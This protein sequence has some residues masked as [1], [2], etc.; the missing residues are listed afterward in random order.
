MVIV[1]GP[2]LCLALLLSGLLGDNGLN[3]AP[4]R[5]GRAIPSSYFGLTINY[6]GQPTSPWPEVP[7]SGIRLWGAIY[8]AE[9]NPAPGVFD[10]KRFDAIL[11]A[12]QRH[13]VDVTFNLAYTPKWASSVS[14]AKPAFSPGAS[15]P[16]ADIGHW[17]SF[18]EAAVKRAAGRIR[19]WEVWN[20]PEDPTYYSGDVA[21][22]VLLQRTAYETIKR[23][24]PTLL[25]I[26]PSSI[27]TAE[28]LRWQSA[29]LA[30]GGGKYAD[31]LG[32]HGYWNDPKPEAIVGI[33]KRFRDLFA[34]HGL[35][36]KPV[37]D[38][39]GGWPATMEDPDAQ[40]AF[41]ARS[42]LIKWA[43]GVDRFHWYAYE[44]GGANYGKL[45]DKSR[46]LLM[47]GRAYR[48]VN[49][50]LVG[51]TMLAIE[52]RGRVWKLDLQLADGRKAL[53]IWTTEGTSTYV[54]SPD[55]VACEDLEGAQMPLRGGKMTIGPKPILFTS[56][57]QKNP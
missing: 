53:A 55:Y 32:F 21:T 22:M 12:S 15:A 49:R 4:D 20:E 29:F 1:V 23:L 3:A 54:A 46:G 18:I 52:R 25:V 41:V 7:F 37:W 27:G 28:G 51:A 44:G 45:W 6:I 11:E 43:I 5:V 2:T 56:K 38:T 10:W 8:W 26:S 13:Q 14:N 35:A 31:I 33:V 40:A 47:P 48:T 19:Y 16:P 34:M 39:E 30:A 17:Q 9:L 50:W 36:D 42:Y 57:D 24:D